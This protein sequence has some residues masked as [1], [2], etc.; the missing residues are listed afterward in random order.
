MSDKKPKVSPFLNAVIGGFT[1]AVEI[2]ITYPTEFVKT[3]MQLYPEMNK[4]GALFCVKNTLK[5]NG[6]FGLYKGYSALLL[7]SVP[8][9]YVRFGGFH[10]ARTNLFKDTKSKLHTFMCGLFAGATEAALVVTPQETLKVKLIHD[11]LSPKPKYTNLFQGIYKISQQYGI[12]GVYAGL[13]P[14][15][16][17]QATN[18]GVRFVVFEDTQKVLHRVIPIKVMADL[19]AGAFAGLCSVMVNNPLDCVK[20]I[21][22]GL[23]AD[24]YKGSLDCARHILKNEGPLGFYKGVGPRLARV[25]A[26]VGLTFAIFNSLKRKLLEL[27][28]KE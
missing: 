25:T 17:K 10:Y 6:Y 21:M 7:F 27:V 8:K 1:G 19:M 2:S 9:N 13:G 24:K 18:Q 4:K 16:L 20:T 5:K 22:Q 15:I 23:E 14:T 3:I 11:K 28:A 26:D 12:G